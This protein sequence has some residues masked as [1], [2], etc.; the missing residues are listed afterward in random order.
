MKCN[1][2]LGVSLLAFASC[3][4]LDQPISSSEG[5]PLESPFQKSIKDPN[6]TGST[7]SAQGTSRTEI[8]PF[9]I[10][11]SVQLAASNIPFYSKLPGFFKR[12]EKTLDKDQRALLEDYRDVYSQILLDSGERGFVET[13]FL[14][15]ARPTQAELNESA[16]AEKAFE[17]PPLPSSS[18]ESLNDEADD[19]SNAEILERIRKRREELE[20][21]NTAEPSGLEV[22]TL[23]ETS[24]EE[25]PSLPTPAAEL[26]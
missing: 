9:P 13:K 25:I 1:L 23:P 8:A 5:N 24:P 17:I 6:F 16:A 22:P 19:L 20:S 18:I 4:T 21:I 3:A 7:R 14:V 10:G 15:N 2:I 11:S 12:S 26:E